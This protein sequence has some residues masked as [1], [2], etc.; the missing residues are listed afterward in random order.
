MPASSAKEHRRPLFASLLLDG[1]KLLGFP[2]SHPLGILLPGSVERFLHSDAQQRHDAADRG[3]IHGV[4]KLAPDQLAQDQQPPQ[5]DLEAV[6]QRRLVCDGLGQPLHS[7][8]VEHGRSTRNRLG[9][10]RLL[11]ALVV[12]G[13]P[14]E[15]RAAMHTVGE[16]QV[17]RLHASFSRLD[18]TQAHD[19]ER[20]MVKLS[21]VGLL[22]GGH[23]PIVRK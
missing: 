7:R 20:G 4:A 2:L 15:N 23:G 18:G 1:G 8:F 16:C 5:P 21:G 6:L 17:A 3:Q 14:A 13:Q 10:E 9:L 12:V 19:L 22:F 11:T